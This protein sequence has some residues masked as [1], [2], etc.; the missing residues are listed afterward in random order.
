MINLQ[1]LRITK[2][3]KSNDH[4]NDIIKRTGWKIL[5]SGTEGIVC[6]H[7][8]K[9][10]VLKIYQNTSRYNQFVEYAQ[11]NQSNPH[12]P[13]FSRFVREVPGTR[14]NYVRMEKLKLCFRPENYR[15]E[16]VYLYLAGINKGVKTLCDSPLSTVR[17]FLVEH[18]PEYLGNYR[19]IVTIDF[20]EVFL[21]L[22]KICGRIPDDEWIVLCNE[23]IDLI[24]KLSKRH[25]D[26]GGGNV[27]LRGKTL[28]ITD[29][30]Y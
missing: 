27:M 11:K 26:V 24:L 29:P 12:L 1:E 8:S 22:R 14:Y 6:E 2:D 28:V 7:P 21:V 25:M 23:L 5:G 20:D 30:F 3:L 4:I 10:Y 16:F 19:N 18:F 13:K 17:E 15:P 9:K